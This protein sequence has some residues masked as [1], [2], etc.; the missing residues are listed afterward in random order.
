[1]SVRRNEKVTVSTSTLAFSIQG[2]PQRRQT[3]VAERAN[4]REGSPR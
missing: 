1:M 3:L 4:K 2:V